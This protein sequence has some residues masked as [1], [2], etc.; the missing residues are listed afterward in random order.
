[1]TFT[2]IK[3]LESHKYFNENKLLNSASAEREQFV[4]SK[5]DNKRHKIILFSFSE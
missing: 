1:M 2:A 4:A 5:M 3:K